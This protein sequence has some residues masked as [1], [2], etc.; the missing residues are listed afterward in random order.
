MTWKPSRADRKRHPELPED[1]CVQ[2]R[3]LVREVQPDN[4]QAPFL[5]ALFTT[6]PSSAQESFRL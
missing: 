3:L 2:G 5:L 4:G 1:A 6:S